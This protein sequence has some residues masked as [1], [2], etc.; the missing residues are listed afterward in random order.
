MKKHILLPT[1]FSDNAWSAVVYALKLYAE[2]ECTFHFIHSTKM[3]VSTM[4]NFSNRL[5]KVMTENALKDLQDIKD[6]ATK[7]NA[8]ANHDFD[9]IISNH[10]LLTAMEIAIKKFNIDLVV[11]GT[12]GATKAKDRFFGSNTVD[13]IKNMELC[14]VFGGT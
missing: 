6:M 3:K 8:N 13:I 9:I 7:T 10:D 2:Q 4:S 5:L 11:M 1:D 12:K 14:P